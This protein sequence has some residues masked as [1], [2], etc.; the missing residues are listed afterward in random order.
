M[1]LAPRA[2]IDFETR[3]ECDLRQSGSWRYSLDPTTEIVCL[4]FRLPYWPEGRTALWHPAFPHLDLPDAVEDDDCATDVVELWQWIERGGLVEAHNA[5][6]E[7]GVWTNILVARFFWPAI[8]HA[9]WRCSAAKAATH[10]LPR[11]LE[12]AAVALKLSTL[13]DT[14]GHDLMRKISKPRKA[15]KAEIQ[16]WENQ[17][18]AGGCLRCKGKG[19]YKRQSCDACGG[20]GVLP[21]PLSS[22]PPLPTLWH[23]SQEL[24]ERI[25]AYCRQDVL[26]EEALSSALPDLSAAETEL[27]LLDQWINERGFQLDEDAV[28]AALQLIDQ[29]TARLNRQLA[30]VTKGEVTKGSQRARLQTWLK[31]RG[32]DLPD[33]QAATV[34]EMLDRTDLPP[35]P[36][37]ALEILQDLGRSSTAK[38]ERMQHWK[39]A[40]GRVRGGLLYHG[41]STGRWTGS[42]VQPHNFVRGTLKI[43]QED[44]WRFLKTGDPDTIRAATDKEGRAIGSVMLALANAL[45]GAICAGPNAQLYVADYASIEARGLLWLADDPHVELF[46]RNEDI[47]CSMASRIYGR[48]VTKANAMERQLGKATV[49]GCGYGMGASKF[50]DAAKAYGVT[51]DED[52]SLSVIQTYRQMFQPVVRLWNEQESAAIDAVTS[53]Q[54]VRCGRITWFVEDEFLYAQLPSRRRLAYPFPLVRNEKSPW[55]AWKFTLSFETISTYTRQWQRERTYGGKIVEN[56][57]QALARDIMAD[58][59]LRCERT[60]I[61]RPVLSVHDEVICEADEGAGDVHEYE[62]L[63]TAPPPWALDCPIAAEGWRGTRYR[64]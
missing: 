55:G 18:Q 41:A 3:S 64:K 13:K 14:E 49:L 9:Q 40:D 19:T 61:Y 24:F 37:R 1:A 51:I 11:S 20:Q 45:R 4:A 2:T 8:G 6:F 21:N 52:F 23:E 56:L 29:E 63:L 57:V 44:L 58:A 27:Y 15:L 16:A 59:L 32:I 12:D 26:T 47:Y 10:A 35:F 53:R 22:V 25:W 38:Y 54:P 34:T 5:W 17:H 28:V 46:R 33:T 7:R 48:P 31:A 43:G 30:L 39:C 42:G 62:Q 60:G 36:R 50:V